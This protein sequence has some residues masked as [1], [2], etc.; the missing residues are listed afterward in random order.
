MNTLYCSIFIV[1]IIYAYFDM[2]NGVPEPNKFVD[3]D[4]VPVRGKPATPIKVSAIKIPVNKT[5][6]VETTPSKE[7]KQK[8]EPKRH[9]RSSQ[10]KDK[11]AKSSSSTLTIG[12]PIVFIITPF[13]ISKFLL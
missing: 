12:S 5:M 4:G 8:N 10:K 11:K 13:V 2:V 9:K 6:K 1:V 3:E 7:K